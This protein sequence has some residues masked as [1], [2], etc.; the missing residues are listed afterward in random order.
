[1]PMQ[2]KIMLSIA[3]FFTLNSYAKSDL[4]QYYLV[5]QKATTEVCKGNFDKANELF[6]LAFKDYHT[7]F[8]TD[9]NNALYA[10]VRSKVIDSVYIKKL[11]TE[12]GTRGIAVKRRYGKK[13]AYTPF[14]PIMDLINSDSLPAM[15]AMA[16][17]LVSDALIS[18]QAIRNISNKFSQPVHYT[19]S[20]TIL[21][22]VRRIDS[23]NYNEVCALLRAAVKKKENLEST[24][25]YPAVEHL[26]LILMHSSPWGY[27]NKELLDSCV[28]FNV[29][30]APLVATLYDNYCVSGYLNTQSAWP[31][32]QDAHKVFGLYGTPVSL[33]FPKSCYLLKVDD[34]VLNTI[35]SRRKQLYLNDAY[36]NARII[37]YAFFFG[38]EGFEYPGISVVEDEGFEQSFEQRLKDKGKKYILYRSKTDFDYNRHW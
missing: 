21:P 36:E 35:N 31:R 25:G 15:D 3:L 33:L 30:Y 5:S 7:A 37:T 17:N 11:F 34:D 10:A 20:T 6:K 16:V 9:L 2:K 22:A 27:Y 19:Q 8:F 12:I 26:K 38:T 23:V 29:L 18:D 4:E 24:I 1:M 28:A 14:I 13:A 32:E